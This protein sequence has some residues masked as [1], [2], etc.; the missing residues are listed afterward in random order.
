MILTLTGM[1]VLYADTAWA[2]VVMHWLGG[3]KAAAVIHRTFA[4]LLATVF[5][6]QLIYFAMQLG[7]NGRRF[8]WF[9]PNS[10]V[11]RWQDLSDIVAMFKWFLGLGPRPVFDRWTYWEKFDYWAPF[12]AVTAHRRH[13]LD[14]VV[15]E[16][17]RDVPAGLGVQRGHDLP[18][19]GGAAG[20]PVPVHGAFL[21][22]PLPAG[23]VPAGCGDVHRLDAS[24]SNSGASTRVEYNR[25]VAAGELEKYLVDAPSEPMTLGS[26]ILGFTLIAF[27]LLLLVFV[28]IGMF[29]GGNGA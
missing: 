3:P 4:V 24:G 9:G 5:F 18:R 23:Q 7:R 20:G 12:A 25:L 6:G 26:K 10:L 2:P 22:Q 13:R 27:G 11:P 21:Q 17:H 1:S 29:A 8:D 16:R 19:R 15:L 28:L 14:A